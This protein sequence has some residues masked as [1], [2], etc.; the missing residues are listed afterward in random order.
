MG[1]TDRNFDSVSIQQDDSR[2]NALFVKGNVTEAALAYFEQQSSNK[3]VAAFVGGSGVDIYNVNGKKNALNIYNNQTEYPTLRVINNGSGVAVYGKQ[4]GTG[5]AAWFEGGSG[6][7]ITGVSG[8]HD[9]L[10]IYNNESEYV[11]A[12]I[13]NNGAGTV[14]SIKQEGSGRIAY[15]EAKGNGEGVTIEGVKGE[16]NALEIRAQTDTD[17]SC[18]YIENDGTSRALRVKQLGV[19]PIAWFQGKSDN[20]KL[21]VNASNDGESIN[22]AIYQAEQAVWKPT[23]NFSDLSLAENITTIENA[24]NKI[25]SL[26]G[27]S[28]SWQNKALGEKREIGVSA[29]KV[30][31]VL[32]ELVDSVENQSGLVKYEKFV[33][34]LIEAIKAQQ[35]QIE[36]LQKKVESLGDKQSTTTTTATELLAKGLEQYNSKQYESAIQTMNQAFELKLDFN[37]IAD[38]SY[39]RARCY[40]LLK[41]DNLALDNLQKALEFKESLVNSIE[42]ESDFNELESNTKFKALIPLFKGILQKSDGNFETA[43]ENIDRSLQINPGFSEY[44]VALNTKANCFWG[45]ERFDDAIALFKVADNYAADD[46]DRYTGFKNLGFLLTDLERYQEAILPLESAFKC[47]DKAEKAGIAL[48][49]RKDLAAVYE[50]QGYALSGLKNYQ[51]AMESFD[52][53]KTCDSNNGW[54]IYGKACCCA[55]LENVDSALENL[56]LALKMEPEILEDVKNDEE[57]DSLRSDPRF[58]AILSTHEFE[59]VDRGWQLNNK[60]QY[61]EALTFFDKVLQLYPES[62]IAMNGKATA[63]CSLNRYQESLEIMEKAI[64]INPDDDESWGIKARTLDL[65]FESYEESLKCYE[66]V[67]ELKPKQQ[68]ALALAWY[69]KSY[70]LAELS[71]YQECIESMNKALEL[72]LESASIADAVYLQAC[73]YA[74]LKENE[75][76]LTYLRKAVELNKE[77]K[78][79]PKE[80]EDWDALRSD[81]RFQMIVATPSSEV[82]S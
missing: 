66:K 11:T 77:V 33:P 2:Y 10:N 70:S 76:A 5:C 46:L 24:L 53:A 32:P 37:E 42:Q 73:C 45:L 82:I 63:L 4:E 7:R 62:V 81:K 29:E 12:A 57:W 74:A 16:N 36:Q 28:F 18:T 79:W 65:G 25:M 22:L 60:Q 26:E 20:A 56:K 48:P 51:Q 68:S 54:A 17:C 64:Q 61:T 21:S 44:F 1:K 39:L 38:A 71:R 49:E 69:Y 55:V 50:T 40:A 3:N 78:D 35:Q 8:K 31:E 30:E 72:N 52:K 67:I 59:A 75:L 6:V 27:V 13:Q 47:Y 9:A 43:L 80:Q 23:N 58:E 41:Q 14:I 34:V 19:G 15:F